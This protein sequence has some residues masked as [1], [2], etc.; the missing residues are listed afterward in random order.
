MR[1]AF[2]RNK[3]SWT[4][5]SRANLF[6]FRASHGPCFSRGKDTRAVRG[7]ESY[8][9]MGCVPATQYQ[10]SKGRQSWRF[11]SVV[12]ATIR[13][14]RIF[15]RSWRRLSHPGRPCMSAASS[16]QIK[17]LS[18]PRARSV[19]SRS[20]SQLQ[21]LWHF[22]TTCKCSA[23]RA[24][25][26]FAWLAIQAAKKPQ[27]KPAIFCAQSPLFRVVSRPSFLIPALVRSQWR[28]S[29]SRLAYPFTHSARSPRQSHHALARGPSRG[30][31]A[32]KA[33]AGARYQ[34]PQSANI[35][36]FKSRAIRHA[37]T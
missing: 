1:R 7:V 16:A 21:A 2:Q 4:L 35:H 24:G 26:L 33:G 9:A 37:Q 29:A 12:L 10:K 6:Y 19:R 36:F 14:S 27:S 23:P 5:H 34:V 3:T 31:R 8:A 11:I 18:M 32:C 30:S 15:P 20:F 13:H 28:A 22:Q 25:G 17:P